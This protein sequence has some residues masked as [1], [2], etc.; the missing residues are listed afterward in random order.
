MKSARWVPRLLLGIVASSCG[1]TGLSPA[2]VPVTP[3]LADAGADSGAVVK[4]S[5]AN[6]DTTVDRDSRDAMPDAG[7]DVP[8][9]A[10]RV[11]YPLTVT[12]A[13]AKGTVTSAPAGIDC[14]ATCVASFP[15]NSVVALTAVPDATSFFMAWAG[16]CAYVSDCVVTMDGPKSVTAQFFPIQHSLTVVAA[17]A[18]GTVALDGLRCGNDSP[19]F[20][21]VAAGEVLTLTA[22]PEAGSYFDGWSGACSGLGDCVVTMS[23]DRSVTAHFGY[24]PGDGRRDAGRTE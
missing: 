16:A 13:L 11:S 3:D 20:V 5:D 10:E 24:L 23:A 8:A 18:P 4:G 22:T 9:D 15:A 19:C 14:G 17:G 12:I 21:P 7:G 1:R 2:T 6:A